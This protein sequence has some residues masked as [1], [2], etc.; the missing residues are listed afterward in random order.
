MRGATS[1]SESSARLVVSF[2]GGVLRPTMDSMENPSFGLVL[3]LLLLWMAAGAT[4]IM[5]G[6]RSPLIEQD[7]RIGRSNGKRSSVCVTGW[8]FLWGAFEL[9]KLRISVFRWNEI[10][11]V[12][13]Q[14]IRMVESFKCYGFWR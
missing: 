13:V 8:G 11:L 2:A 4:G 1:P 12:I 6:L 5:L 9:V 10:E 3:G 7:Q 14:F